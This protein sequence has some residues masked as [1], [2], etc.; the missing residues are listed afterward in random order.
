M[1]GLKDFKALEQVTLP[2]IGDL[3]CSGLILIVGPNSSGKTQLL[4]DIYLP[5]TGTPRNSVVAKNVRIKQLEFS[6]L[7]QSLE[8]EGYLRTSAE[9]QLIPQT[10]YFGSGQLFQPVQ[11]HQAQ[12]WYDTYRASPPTTPSRPIEFLNHFGRFLVSALFLDRRLTSLATVGLIDFVNQPPQHDIHAL[13]VNEEV[14]N[15]LTSEIMDSFGRALWADISRGNSLCLRVNDGEM[16]SHEDRLSFKKMEKYRTIETEG[17]G[18]KSYVAICI[19]MLLGD[20]PI[21]IIDEPEMCL[22]PPQ[23]YNLGRFIG[24]HGSATDTVTFVATHS[25]HILRGII[26]ATKQLQIVRLSRRDSQFSAHLVPAN[27][28][29][30]ALARPTLR[31]ESV[32][33]GIFADCVVVLEADTDRLVY[34]TTL[35]TLATE[36]RIDVHFTAVGG[37]GGIAATCSLYR[38]LNIPVAVIADLDMLVDVARLSR[39]VEV[40]T[41][42]ETAQSLVDRAKSLTEI[43]RKLPPSIEPD[44]LRTRLT[45]IVAMETDWTSGDDAK[46]RREL[47]RMSEQLDR[48]RRLKRGGISS[49]SEPLA[50]QL[51]SLVDDLASIG[52]FLVPVGEL[53]EWLESEQIQ[54]SKENKWA[55]ANEAALKIQNKGPSRGGVWDFMRKVST[56]LLH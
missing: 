32:L 24:R 36:F 22:H 2:D 42:K 11:K 47:N 45:A 10:T 54:A 6:S 30:T 41:N 20:R 5:L 1:V 23:A 3:R 46:M 15:A 50:S 13:Y 49:F 26:Q 44:E 53:E 27:V 56:Y 14:R 43:L 28:L 33:D 38:T 40:L 12:N 8:S 9:G 19:A 37:T 35:E 52:L 17:D 48:M 29:M 39:V 16:P 31:N 7:L 51:T 25:S 18:L 34:Q 21:S 55:W 4:Q